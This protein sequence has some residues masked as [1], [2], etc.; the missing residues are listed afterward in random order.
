MLDA[1]ALMALARGD[2]RA[3]AILELAIDE[4]LLVQVPT[5]VLAQV[6]RGDRDRA[7]SG[8][9][10]QSVNEFLAT[11]ESTARDAGEILGRAGRSD[12]V[13]AIVAAEALRGTPAAI[14]TSD[15]TDL[16]D[17][18]DAGDGRTRVSVMAVQDPQST[19]YS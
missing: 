10:L 2:R 14:L 19:R 3:R 15:P 7:R 18:I 12:A 16:S 11:T 13:D 5:P 1:G 8:R 17:L 4:G 9:L 6:H